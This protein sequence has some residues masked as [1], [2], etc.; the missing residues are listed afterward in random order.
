MLWK[1]N[2]CI[3]FVLFIFRYIK[4]IETIELALGSIIV[5]D[6]QVDQWDDIK[7]IKA[8]ISEMDTKLAEVISACSKIRA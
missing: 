1:N 2:T 8:K 4:A 6:F 3:M 7:E 5:V